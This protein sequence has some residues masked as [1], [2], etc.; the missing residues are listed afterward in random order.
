MQTPVRPPQKRQARSSSRK[1]L[2]E[3]N[4]SVATDDSLMSHGNESL[5]SACTSYTDFQVRENNTSQLAVTDHYTSFHPTQRGLM[6][7][8]DSAKTARSSAIPRSSSMDNVV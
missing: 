2:T 3:R 5:A 8:F 1:I 4:A 7:G 6:Q